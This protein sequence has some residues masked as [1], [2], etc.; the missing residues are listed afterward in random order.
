LIFLPI[1]NVPEVEV[2]VPPDNEN[3]PDDK[4]IDELLPV[5]VPEACVK[6]PL[7]RP[8]VKVIV[9]PVF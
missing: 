4:V 6:A 7:E 2:N 1:E 5:N 9:T 8:D 3:P